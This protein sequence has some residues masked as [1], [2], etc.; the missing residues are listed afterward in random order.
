MSVLDLFETEN[1]APH[2]LVLASAGTGKT[3]QLAN[4]FAGL[5]AAGVAPERILATTFTRKAAGEILDRVLA[6]LAEAAAEGPEGERARADLNRTA[7]AVSPAIEDELSAEYCRSI[8]ATLLRR[9]D[10]FQVRTLD[11]FFVALA[12]LFTMELGIAP[13]WRIADDVEQRAIVL[14]GVARVIEE[15]NFEEQVTLLRGVASSALGR[16][17][18]GALAS[19]VMAA[20]ELARVAP[21]DAWDGVPP[22]QWPDEAQVEEAKRVVAEA[23]P[24]TTSSG[25]P[26]KPWQS[27]LDQVRE[28]LVLDPHDPAFTATTPGLVSKAID[29]QDT[30]ARKPIPDALGDAL[31]VIGWLQAAAGIAQV[32]QRNHANARLLAQY[33]DVDRVLRGELGV[34]RFS[35]FSRALLLGPAAADPR[36]WISDL[37][38]R[39]DG[40]LDHL[41]LDEFQDTAPAQ[42]RLLEPL[43]SEV[44]SGGEG[45]AGAPRSFFCVGD[46]KQSIYGWR[47]AEPALLAR[48]GDRMP[49]L[50]VEALADSWRSSQVVLDT[51]NHVFEGI[52]D[53][54]CLAGDE[55]TAAREAAA[56]WES[57]FAAH[58]T[59]PPL[60]DAL[61]GEARM[62][63]ARAKGGDET[64]GAPAIELAVER[65]AAIAED[66]PNASIA[67]LVRA[68]AEIPRIRYGL[69]ERGLE[70][71]DE[72]G[73]PLTDSMGVT[74]ILAAL[75]LA[76]HPGDG[77]A[78]LQVARS[79]FARE[80]GLS[81]EE[82]ET[83]R[84]RE[85]AE[86]TARRVREDVLHRGY[87]AFCAERAAALSDEASDWDARR[88][89][90]LVDLALAYDERA[91][92]RPIDFVDLVRSQ[93][94]PD[95]TAS[96][97]KV[98]TIHASK[99]LEFDAVLLPE[100]G[101]SIRLTPDGIL[102]RRASESEAPNLLSVV[103]R[104][105]L[106]SQHG[107]L[108]E[109]YEAAEKRAMTDA[110][111][112]LYVAMTRAKHCIELIVPP[113]ADSKKRPPA[114][115]SSNLVRPA[116]ELRDVDSGGADEGGPVL[117]WEHEDSNTRWD[118]AV[119]LGSVSYVV[120]PTLDLAPAPRVAQ[121]TVVHPS[122]IDGEAVDSV[123]S[124][125]RLGTLVHALL[126]GVVWLEDE[127]RTDED[128]R[129]ACARVD[130][131]PDAP[132]EEA[133][134]RFRA[135]L[136]SDAGRDVLARRSGDVRVLNERAFDV[137][138]SNDEGTFRMRGTIDRLIL[139]EAD[140]R[141]VSAEI[142]DFKTVAAMR[143]EAVVESSRAQIDAY[144][145]AVEQLFGLEE[146]SVTASI[147]WLPGQSKAAR[148]PF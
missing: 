97:I 24:P 66:H 35:D 71:S 88:L 116:F 143:G 110:L 62:W 72:G 137:E 39:I 144:R 135:A 124:S 37:A 86:R 148:L 6:R 118:Q 99:G 13:V 12:R 107:A 25:S 53:R 54:A 46:V 79:P 22:M 101:K 2:R 8:L 119:S 141:V 75:Q 96:R 89:E 125:S 31:R 120:E 3:Y 121:E 48:M 117:L 147:L 145:R 106:A 103:P 65:V 11:S 9:I 69:G 44:V 84:G 134:A 73:N 112:A 82:V 115:R 108:G 14:E 130:R 92:L 87:G 80:F 52:A 47:G 57:G 40:R 33:V 15:L 131:G 50:D 93:R 55:R 42:W 32:V 43:A 27:A 58:G 146:S 17:A 128:L 85:V 122:T 60:K 78:R 61:L 140:G 10:R 28:L 126:E 7:R 67:V 105:A 1:K 21:G 98:M 20:D 123:E 45:G 76:D 81:L 49:A 90:Q 83:E 38:Y 74:W 142:V 136:E 129:A 95:P 51:V 5:L 102:S 114:L 26:H 111:S 23:K 77:V 127:A 132:V 19:A 34:Y 94:I 63:Q 30:F 59:A 139:Q 41:L 109:V 100:L 68:K 36:Q 16:D 64:E 104:K 70:A 29:S 133:I 113:V 138:A 4:H 18:S 56:E 91:T